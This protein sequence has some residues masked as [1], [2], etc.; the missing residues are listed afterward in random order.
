M[1][2]KAASILALG[3]ALSAPTIPHAQEDMASR[4]RLWTRQ[5]AGTDD[6]RAS[7]IARTAAGEFLIAGEFSGTI[8]LDPGPGAIPL[9]ATGP[10][11]IF[12]AKLDAG[13]R[14]LWARRL[15]GSGF[16]QIALYRGLVT[17]DAGSLYVGGSFDGTIDS[18]RG[19]VSTS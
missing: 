8:D 4:D 9:T 15:G 19:P 17:G 10:Q 3:V 7:G 11:D 1:R 6:L 5:I 12:V 13:G 2:N 14:F 16:A 18:I